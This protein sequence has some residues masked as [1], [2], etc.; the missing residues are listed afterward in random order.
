MTASVFVGTSLDGF[1]ARLD[2]SFDFLPA[3]GGEAHGYDEFMAGIDAIVMGRNTFDVDAPPRGI[4]QRDQL[5]V[6]DAHLARTLAG[7]LQRGVQH[8]RARIALS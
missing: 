4:L 7:S 6:A 3:D 2:G 1:I 5:A 8:G